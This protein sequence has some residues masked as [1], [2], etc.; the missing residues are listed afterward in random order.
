[1][2]LLSTC[3]GLIGLLFSV[4]PYLSTSWSTPLAFGFWWLSVVLFL[5]CL[6]MVSLRC[7]LHWE[8]IAILP[9]NHS[10][11]LFFA[12]YILISFG[13]LVEGF[14]RY[15]PHY[16]GSGFYTVAIVFWWITAVLSHIA[17]ILI[18]FYLAYYHSRT[19]AELSTLWLLAMF[20]GVVIGVAARHI[21]YMTYLLL[22]AALPLV[23]VTLGMLLARF[24]FMGLLSCLTVVAFMFLG[25]CIWFLTFG[26]L[27]CLATAIKNKGIPFTTGWWGGVFPTGLAG[28]LAVELGVL[29]GIDALKIV[30]STLSVFTGLLGAYCTARTSAQVYSGVI[31]NADI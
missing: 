18:P 8:T 23:L 5:I 9:K 30:G 6:T 4:N 17:N 24:F 11:D 14:V 29:L 26:M 3:T 12:G 19:F 7:I 21:L 20:P 13:I 15:C 16:I 2:F 25:S 22:G 31:F 27:V 28:L 10:F 1:M